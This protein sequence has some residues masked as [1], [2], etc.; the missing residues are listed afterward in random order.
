MKTSVFFR[1]VSLGVLM[2]MVI[3][4]AIPY[5]AIAQEQSRVYSFVDGSNEHPTDYIDTTNEIHPF[6][7][8]SEDILSM[9]WTQLS[10]ETVLEIH[11]TFDRSM[12]QLAAYFY[13]DLLQLLI[14]EE[15]SNINSYSDLQIITTYDSLNREKKTL[16][17]SLTP[18]V[19]QK[20]TELKQ[21]NKETE[22]Q[23]VL[24]VQYTEK[25]QEFRFS[26]SKTEQS[27]DEV[28]RAAN[29]VEQDLYLPGKH[30]LDVNLNRRY[31]SLS[32]KI[33]L[34]GWNEDQTANLSQESNETFATGWDF[35]VPTFEIVDKEQMAYVVDDNRN[36]QQEIYK[37]KIEKEPRSNRY[38]IQLEDGT[39]L[40]YKNGAFVNYPYK[41]AVLQT[42]V[43]SHKYTL[44]IRN[45]KYEFDLNRNTV[46]KSNIYGDKITYFNRSDGELLAIEDSVGR[47]I[48]LGSKENMPNTPTQDLIVYTNKSRS[49]PIKHLRY[50]FESKFGLHSYQQLKKVE[51]LPLN[52]ENGTPV[53]IAS[54]SYYNPSVKGIGYFNLNKNYTLEKLP[55]DQSL[56]ES[57]KYLD[58]DKTNREKLDY[59]LLQE[60][61][62]PLQGLKIN[63]DYRAYQL[64]QKTFKDGLARIFLDKYALSY[65]SY[66]PVTKVTYN[67]TLKTPQ[68]T[69]VYSLEKS[70]VENDN[71]REIW[72]MPKNQITR[73]SNFA[74]RQ[75]DTIVV[76]EKQPSKYTVT[77]T[78]KLNQDGTPL[79]RTVKT[80]GISKGGT[81]VTNA[82]SR[83]SYN[84]TSYTSFAYAGR[85]TKPTYQYNFLE[86]TSEVGDT[87][88]FNNYLKDPVIANRSRYASKISNFALE[89]YME[90]DAYGQ[91]IKQLDPDGV[92]TNW[93]YEL[94]AKGG[95]QAFSLLKSVNTQATAVSSDPY[96]HNEI[97]D[98][99]SSYLV[100]KITSIDSYPVNMTAYKS[101]VKEQSYEYNNNLLYSTTEKDGTGKTLT[102]TY[103]A[104][105]QYGLQ[106]VRVSLTGVDLGT[107]K[108]DVLDLQ[109]KYNDKSELTSQTYPDGSKVTYVYDFLGRQKKVEYQNQGSSRSVAY[110]YKDGQG[111]DGTGIV[112]KTL[113]DST[114][115]IT[116]YTPYGDIAYQEQVGTDG[117]KRA[118]VSNEFT[119]DGL[120][121]SRTLPYA[122]NAKSVSYLYD[123]DGFLY[124]SADAVGVTTYNRNNA[125]SESGKYLPRL[126]EQAVSPNGYITTTYRDQYGRIE[127]EEESTK[128]GN[129]LRNTYYQMD[130]FGKV[131]D[132]EVTDGSTSLN[133]NLRYDNNGKL[134]Y[135]RDPESNVHE[136]TYDG[137]GN[138][139]SVLENGVTSA[140]Y[141]YNAL[142]WKLSEKNPE[143]RAETYVYSKNGT[144]ASVKDKNGVTFTYNYT[145]FNELTKVTSGTGFFEEHIYDRAS[146]MLQS[147]NSSYGHGITYG[148]DAFQRN[149]R[150]TMM[151][152]D[153]LL[154]YDDID[155]QL[156]A[157]V[158][159]ARTSV[160]GA[161]VPSMKVGYSF[162]G[163][164]RLK[165]VS[166]P[167]VGS[168]SYSYDVN[169]SGE[170]DTVSYPSQSIA[171]QQ[172]VNSFGEAT[173]L[174]HADGWIETNGYDSFGNIISQKRTGS[175]DGTFVYDNIFRIKE[176]T[177]GGTKRQYAYDRRGNR[178]MYANA[179]ASITASYELK[180]DVLNRMTEYKDEN[181]KTSYTYYP[182]GLRATKQQTGTVTDTTQYVYL[183]GQIIEELTQDGKTKARNVFGNQLIWRKDYASNQEGNY[184][185][186]THGD[187]VKIVA[188]NGSVLNSY[189]Y[190]IWG[191]LNKA[192]TKESMSNPFMY[193]GEVYDKESGFY[194]LRARYYDPKIGR[195]ISEDTYKGQVD[196]P[197]SLNRY[198]YTH[199]NPMK[200]VDPSGNKPAQ[201]GDSFYEEYV[202]KVYQDVNNGIRSL[203]G[204]SEQ[205]SRLVKKRIYAPA[206]ESGPET[207]INGVAVSGV[208]LE[209]VFVIGAYLEYRAIKAFTPG[210]LNNGASNVNSKI[211]LEAKL[212]A[213]EFSSAFLVNGK[214]NNM[215]VSTSRPIISGDKLKDTRVIQELTKNGSNI[216]EWAKMS[217]PTYQSRYGDFQ[218]HY[219]Q[220]LR[221]GDVSTYDAKLKLN[222]QSRGVITIQEILDLLK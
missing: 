156:D 79:L 89:T 81:N 121:V 56:Q 157:I 170:T 196:N 222:D 147:E 119:P 95:F 207:F 146:G 102:Q 1:C 26:R 166:I 37:T 208:A 204:A 34:P 94:G 24:P 188:P 32:S 110:S 178:Q 100:K 173:S 62:Y 11:T 76:N 57:S 153:Y 189:D 58:A 55:T 27:V 17:N 4:T 206:F 129:K 215:V 2:A 66:H 221:T 20:V 220:N 152:K 213:E 78:Y 175:P 177:A 108:S 214:L 219:Y 46:V 67:Y 167:G 139:T 83:V 92:L 122:D 149:N 202:D 218:F 30:G 197:L 14:E 16:L 15:K 33:S 120:Q 80:T 65:I 179:S 13:S 28:Y 5:A 98:Y 150:V 212:A 47:Y 22:I 209:S 134:V 25:E 93:V 130:R 75:G 45:V 126:T 205:T 168:T 109:L 90:Y 107:G 137:W 142:S 68:G 187:V 144:L 192:N 69:S 155:D 198:T 97:Y 43:L 88:T 3:T 185:Y 190:D 99:T 31:H 7:T 203:E 111:T 23:D 51:M 105:D 151:G 117:S 49:T 211:Q 10:P 191:N 48:D 8:S 136:Y 161:S 103:P 199:N 86:P 40:E 217:S 128:R 104:Y 72:K 6:E 135:L 154:N 160:G 216:N 35:N 116:Y 61:S 19:L 131:T 74:E 52:N 112:E 64:D 87:S 44:H 140:S 70:Y 174:N 127:A 172:S 141:T 21:Q 201:Y 114:K 18:N 184:Y 133:W 82:K 101:N 123:W 118:L 164:N 60:A 125:S 194:Y 181:G 91:M 132:K 9:T 41:D 73:L 182:N 113:A 42:D 169:A 145:P 85:D 63:Y 143:T 159:P 124:Q 163:A 59:L 36:P 53:T 54:Y 176:E 200:Y 195:F 210:Q 186:N 162:D 165:S 148:Y 39:S 96:Q 38:F 180:H 84:P 29:I 171:M 71:F 138:L 12:L 106:P 115:V 183:N 193:A 50:Y 77:K 158:Y